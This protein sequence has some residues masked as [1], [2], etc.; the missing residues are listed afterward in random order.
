MLY[1]IVYK[2]NTQISEIAVIRQIKVCKYNCQNELIRLNS[3]LTSLVEHVLVDYGL[4]LFS[5]S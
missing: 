5:F 3:R 4:F 2:V 1:H